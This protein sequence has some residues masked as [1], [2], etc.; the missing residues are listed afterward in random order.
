L[1]DP[2]LGSLKK[3]RVVAKKKAPNTAGDA[4]RGIEESGDRFAEWAAQNAALILGA[5]AIV[6]VLAA[7]TGLY[8]QHRSTARDEAADALADASSNYRLAMGADV[9]A[10]KIE[11]PANLE[12]AERAR[13]EYA[14]KFEEIAR[15]H[16]GTS[17]GALAWLEA[18]NLQAALGKTQHAVVSFESARDAATGQA[19]E[20]IASTRLAGLAEDRGDSAGAAEAFERAGGVEAYPL[21]GEALTEAARCWVAAGETDRALAVYQRFETEFPDEFVAPQIEALIAELRLAH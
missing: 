15:A 6:L 4:L 16:Q 19:I 7:G 13:T 2:E 8:I 17:A 18:G 21:R 5:I 10:G 14:K 12:L 20:A 1:I 3:D 9:S 11:E